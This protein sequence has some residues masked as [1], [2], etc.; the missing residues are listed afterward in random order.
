MKRVNRRTAKI[1]ENKLGMTLEEAA[2]LLAARG[3]AAPGGAAPAAGPAPS[4]APAAPAA[5]AGESDRDRR[6]RIKL[7]EDN[8]K[9]RERLT[10]QKDRTKR[11]RRNERDNTEAMEMRLNAVATGISDEHADFALELFRKAVA[12]MPEDKYPEP[13]A[14]FAGLKAKRAYL[15]T[16]GVPAERVPVPGSSAAPES[17]QPG[18]GQDEGGGGR[19]PAPVDVDKMTAQE[20]KDYRERTYGAI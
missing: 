12:A 14:F 13:R 15:F 17:R 2:E 3:E 10:R 16:G 20:F 4:A 8:A 18:G 9:L 11:V 6:K 7:E 5:P 19:A 1:I